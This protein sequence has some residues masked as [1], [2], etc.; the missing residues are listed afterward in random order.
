MVCL[1][2]CG[3]GCVVLLVGVVAA[4]AVLFLAMVAAVCVGYLLGVRVDFLVCFA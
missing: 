4:V 3:D 1:V 2:L